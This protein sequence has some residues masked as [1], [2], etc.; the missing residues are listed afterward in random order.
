MGLH[1]VVESCGR[2]T[3]LAEWGP[4]GGGASA[5]AAALQG[6]RVGYDL[7]AQVKCARRQADPPT[8]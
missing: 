5:L 3:Y 6:P 4:Q 2:R 7:A 1:T 8:Q